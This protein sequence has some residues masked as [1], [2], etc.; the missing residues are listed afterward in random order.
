MGAIPDAVSQEI[1]AEMASVANEFVNR[2]VSDAPVDQGLLKNL[3]TCYREGVM[4]WKITSGANYSAF[5]EFGTRSRVQVPSDLAEYAAQFKGENPTG[6][7]FYEFAMS[8]LK[9]MERKG[10]T[11]GSYDVKTRK[12]VG[13]NEEKFDEDVRLA[14]AIAYSI[15]KKGVKPHPYFFKQ[16]PQAQADMNRNLSAVVQR[17][18]NS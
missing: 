11:A 8:I 17:A 7:G 6:G 12:R 3:I 2:A 1:D 10:I 13:T 9:W 14:E 5:I 16:L 15:L 4:D 18:L